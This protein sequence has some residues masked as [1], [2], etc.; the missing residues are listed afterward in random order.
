MA[1]SA[2]WTPQSSVSEEIVIS[3]TLLRSPVDG[4]R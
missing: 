3:A 1:Y 2:F 4:G